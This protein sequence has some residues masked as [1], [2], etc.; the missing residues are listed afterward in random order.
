[1]VSLYHAK[2]LRFTT[3]QFLYNILLVFAA[4][5]I[6]PSLLSLLRA[7]LHRPSFHRYSTFF[8]V[9]Y[10]FAVDGDSCFLE[11]TIASCAAKILPALRC[12]EPSL[13]TTSSSSPFQLPFAHIHLPQNLIL[14]VPLPGKVLSQA[15]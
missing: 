4:S 11:S 13:G 2:I 9:N 14:C 7:S 1:M 12:Q 10:I 15:E 6:F 5:C 8:S 3:M